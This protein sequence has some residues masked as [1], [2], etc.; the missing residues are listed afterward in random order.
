[1]T[2]FLNSCSCLW[3][4]WEG[5]THTPKKLST[6]DLEMFSFFF[7]SKGWVR[8]G[9]QNDWNMILHQRFSS[10]TCGTLFYFATICL[11]LNKLLSRTWGIWLF[12]KHKEI[13][14][15]FSSLGALLF[16]LAF[17]RNSKEEMRELYICNITA[18]HR[19]P[20]RFPC[21]GW[22]NHFLITFLDPL[23]LNF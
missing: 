1:M 4:F 2:L 20:W 9:I 18:E 8:R 7:H 23:I 17:I 13:S 19:S 21:V 3:F 16:N 6:V 15:I 5:I 12:N 11:Y 10:S 14:Q 22:S